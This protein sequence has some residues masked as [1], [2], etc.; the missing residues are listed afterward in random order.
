VVAIYEC[1]ITAVL[2]VL[3]GNV[4]ANLTVL[5]RLRAVVPPE[6]GPLVSVLVPAR[7][8]ARNVEDCVRSL[9]LQDYPRYE[10]IVLDDDSEDGTGAIVARLISEVRNPRVSARL[11]RGAALPDGWVGKNWACHQL[12]E[13]AAGEFLLFTDADTTHSPGTISAAVVYACRN[14]ASLVSAW[15]RLLTGTLGEKLIVPMVPLMGM[16]FCPL[17]L[18]RLWQRRPNLAHAGYARRA[19]AA[20]GQFLL[21]AR[22]AYE[23]IGGHAARPDHVVEDV[24]F[25]REVAGRMSEGMRLFNCDGG[26]LSTVR[27]YRSFGETWAGFTKNMRAVFEDQGVLFWVFGVVEWACLL[28]PHWRVF[29]ASEGLRSLLIAQ[30]VIIYAIRFLLAWRMRTSW[31][32]A[33]LHPL[34]VVLMMLIALN[35]WRRSLWGGVEWKGRIYKPRL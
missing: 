19:G 2:L 18:L 12:A 34:G 26:L 13:A 22:E 25:G 27:M 10:L 35:S 15:P 14:N 29:S 31:L 21:F 33:L 16:A 11:L 23:H 8:E 32:G 24:A 5:T 6:S 17:W 28:A 30:L 7:N 3:L 4:I 9:L 1:L 20:N